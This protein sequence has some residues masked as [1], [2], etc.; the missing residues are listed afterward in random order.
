MYDQSVSGVE[1][2][3]AIETVS[4]IDVPAYGVLH[5]VPVEMRSETNTRSKAP[6]AVR[7]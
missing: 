1:L 2:F 3:D 4:I 5:A 7:A 6:V